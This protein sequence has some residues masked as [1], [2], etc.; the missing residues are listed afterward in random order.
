MQQLKFIHEKKITEMYF[1]EGKTASE[2]NIKLGRYF[3]KDQ[4][5]YFIA[6]SCATHDGENIIIPSKLNYL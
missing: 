3:G 6:R 5:S 2:I 1:I 4:I